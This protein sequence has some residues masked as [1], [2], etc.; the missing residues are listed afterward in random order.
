[1]AS[2][3]PRRGEGIGKTEMLGGVRRSLVDSG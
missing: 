1:M 2:I 3:V